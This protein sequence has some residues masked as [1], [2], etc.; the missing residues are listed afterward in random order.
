M[1]NALIA[2][3]LMIILV[4][5]GY[6][7][8]N[9]QN[10][11]SEST[12]TTSRPVATQQGETFTLGNLG[13]TISLQAATTNASSK[14]L[15]PKM[16]EAKIHGLVL[17][18]NGA[19]VKDAEVL[20]THPPAVEK[21]LTPT[22]KAN[23]WHT[24]TAQDGSFS[25]TTLTPG[26]HVVFARQGNQH[27]VTFVA[28]NDETTPGDVTLRLGASRALTGQLKDNEGVPVQHA[29]V[30]P[31]TTE[32]EIHPHLFLPAHSN[33]SGN[34]DFQFLNARIAAL[35]VVAKDYAPITIP[36]EEGSESVSGTLNIGKSF[37]GLLFNEKTQRYHNN[38]RIELIEKHY[39]LERYVTNSK[40]GGVFSFDTL[41]PG[42][43][44]LRLAADA[45]TLPGGSQEIEIVSGETLPDLELS[46]IRAGQIRGRI[47][48]AK[49]RSGVRNVV[50]TA[51]SGS[52]ASLVRS[53]KTDMAGYYMITGLSEGTYALQAVAPT[54]FVIEDPATVT[55][56]AQAGKQIKGPDFKLGQGVNIKGKVLTAAGQPATDA[57]VRLSLSADT[58]ASRSTRTDGEGL[59]VLK[60]VSPNTEV[61]IWAEKGTQTSIGYGP[62][63]AGEE[64]LE[65]L[66]FTLDY[67]KGASIA[68][69]VTDGEGTPRADILVHCYVPDASL[70]R[71]L[72]TKTDGQGQ[73]SFIDLIAG[74]YR[75]QAGTD[76]GSMESASPLQITVEE[77]TPFEQAD[78]TLP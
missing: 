12:S 26:R 9:K 32:S 25:I 41:R 34:F 55:L 4:N 74:N 53:D 64:G 19:P 46:L 42:T 16:G 21:L 11:D 17:D 54:P 24:N 70:D 63:K 1:R 65:G 50:V 45:Y 15:N 30:Y 3:C 23:R 14:N 75:L 78:I 57:S 47:M 37:S 72:Q 35:L 58:V 27:D 62:V 76:A 28:L 2:L 44:T 43:Y 20:V 40:N 49:G 48:D 31:L 13:R 6:L 29:R 71:P 18:S 38:I 59:F 61:R 66:T 39:G 33:E 52:D 8:Y 51:T 60:N 68:G 77:G 69:T 7:Y 5:V 10:P 22:A 36:L 73:Y 56:E 67:R